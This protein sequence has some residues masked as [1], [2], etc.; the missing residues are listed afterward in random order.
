MGNPKL[1]QLLTTLFIIGGFEN[2]ICK[3][4]ISNDSHPMADHRPQYF[5]NC[6]T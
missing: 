1:H 3:I 5:E 2:A 6:G 4:L